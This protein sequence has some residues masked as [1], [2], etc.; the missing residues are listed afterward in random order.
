MLV[1]TLGVT[2]ARLGEVIGSPTS[3]GLRV[4][5]FELNG[6][7][8]LVTIITE[9]VRGHPPRVVPLPE[10]FPPILNNYIVWNGV[11]DKLFNISPTHAWRLVK[12]EANVHP[13]E[14]R[15][16]FALYSLWRGMNPEVLRRIMGHSSLKMTFTY[17][18]AVGLD[19]RQL[20]SPFAD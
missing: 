3:P 5:D 12:R 19:P 16:G 6:N 18:N 7:P 11:Y 13:H 14:L 17:M 2:G 1:L 20:R 8:P 4:M 9:K 10:W 15:H